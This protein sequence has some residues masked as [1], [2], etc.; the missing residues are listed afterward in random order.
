MFTGIV[1]ISRKTHSRLHV[2]Y[3]LFGVA[4]RRDRFLS[5]RGQ[6]VSC[7]TSAPM[8]DGGGRKTKGVPQVCYACDVCRVLLCRDCFHEK[9]DHYSRGL[10]QEHVT[11]V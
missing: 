11:L 5:V 7:Y 2:D 10:P 3:L 8:S 9:Y 1:Q 6:C 4:N